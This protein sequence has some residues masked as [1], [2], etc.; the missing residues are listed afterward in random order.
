MA[1]ANWFR[2]RLLSAN[3]SSHA[4]LPTI[5]PTPSEIPSAKPRVSADPLSQLSAFHCLTF[6]STTTTTVTSPEADPAATTTQRHSASGFA[7]N[8][9]LFF[10]L[11]FDVSAP[12][13][14]VSRTIYTVCPWARQEL[15]PPLDRA[16]SECDINSILYAL[17]SYTTLARTRATVFAAL[18]RAFP[19]LL[20]VLSPREGCRRELVSWLGVTLLRFRRRD[21][22]G[23][24]SGDGVEL[25]ISWN[26]T[27]GIGGEAE[28][29][30]A[31]D[32]RI[33]GHCMA[34]PTCSLF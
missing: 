32:V 28:S 8:R 20:P 25:V 4:S 21:A 17:S 5:C 15:Q 10:K 29:C 3:D 24:G 33:P 11:T 26:I 13:L 6:T 22:G 14:D 7:A 9:L 34:P 23:S 2:K 30:V 18:G 1:I 19:N 27:I 31:A 16:A 12:A